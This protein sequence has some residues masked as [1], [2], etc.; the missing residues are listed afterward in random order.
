MD[1]VGYVMAPT[2][3]V[4][5]RDASVG[6]LIYHDTGLLISSTC[7]YESISP[8]GAQIV[9]HGSASRVILSSVLCEPCFS[10]DFLIALLTS[11]TQCSI[12]M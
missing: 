9:E 2:G 6:L 4:K 5:R 11:E 8:L 1:R 7:R 3:E 10:D 12:Y